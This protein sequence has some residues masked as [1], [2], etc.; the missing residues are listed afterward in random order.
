MAKSQDI[1]LHG[2]A[3]ATIKRYGFNFNLRKPVIDE[4]SALDP[5]K[6]MGGI[7]GDTKDLRGLLWSSIDNAD[8]LDLDQ[9]EYCERGS[10]DEIIVRIAIADVDLFVP[11]SS[12]ADVYAALNGT[13]VYT[14]IENFPML[15]IHLSNGLT[16]L[17]PDADHAAL[18]VE[19]SVFSDGSNVPGKIYR[20]LIRNKAKLVYEEIGGWIEGRTDIPAS[21][22]GVP[23]LKEQLYLQDEAAARLNKFRIKQGLIEFGTIEPKLVLKGEKVKSIFVEEKSRANSIIE[24]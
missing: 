5:D 8:S 10:N 23:G 11:K 12:Q 18:V 15:P 22:S 4:I 1:D 7:R 19:Y 24:N 9:L 17:L 2:I 21:V 16:S 20:A 6:L 3:R 13:S 14:G